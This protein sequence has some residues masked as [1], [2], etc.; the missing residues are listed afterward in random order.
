MLEEVNCTIKNKYG[1]IIYSKR[2]LTLVIDNILKYV[3]I[4]YKFKSIEF[5]HFIK[6]VSSQKNLIITLSKNNGGCFYINKI[7]DMQKYI[8]SLINNSLCIQ[9][10]NFILVYE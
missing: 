8:Y 6:N 9:N 4:D 3:G 2:V 5:S 7:C 1:Q 10:F